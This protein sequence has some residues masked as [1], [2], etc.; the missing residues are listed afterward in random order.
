MAITA[1][2]ALE[3]LARPE[4]F[5]AALTVPGVIRQVRLHAQGPGHERAL[6]LFGVDEGFEFSPGVRIGLVVQLQHRAMQDRPQPGQ[7]RSHR[8][9]RHTRRPRQ[10]SSR[11]STM[12][13]PHLTG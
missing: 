5:A 2:T 4:P 6:S 12:T 8:H 3:H 1:R 11:T 10:T 7:L 13:D 9:S